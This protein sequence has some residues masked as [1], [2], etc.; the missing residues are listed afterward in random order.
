MT[1]IIIVVCGILAVLAE[2]VF[3]IKHYAFYYIFGFIVGNLVAAIK[4]LS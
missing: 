3:K 1:I 4:F 2:E